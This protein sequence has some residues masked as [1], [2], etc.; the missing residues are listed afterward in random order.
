MAGLMGRGVIRG[1][2]GG[3]ARSHRCAPVGSESVTKGSLMRALNVASGLV[4]GPKGCF[5]LVSWIEE[6]CTRVNG[7][8]SLYIAS[9]SL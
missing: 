6:Q 8:D 7:A 2:I 3:E 1:V 9:E 5:V 4:R